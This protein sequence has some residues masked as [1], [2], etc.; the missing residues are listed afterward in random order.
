MPTE[1]PVDGD[2]TATVAA[3]GRQLLLL[4][5]DDRAGRAWLASVPRPVQKHLVGS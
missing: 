1:V 4:T 3:H 2:R 5:D